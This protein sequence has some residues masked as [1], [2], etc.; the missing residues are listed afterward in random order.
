MDIHCHL[1]IDIINLYIDF[2]TIQWA[3]I[4]VHQYHMPKNHLSFYNQNIFYLNIIF[5]IF[6]IKFKRNK[7]TM[8]FEIYLNP[9]SH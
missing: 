5:N 9:L 4:M 2:V 6:I 3:N 8:T 7:I 1:T